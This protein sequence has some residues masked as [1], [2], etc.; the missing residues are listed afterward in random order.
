MMFLVSALSVVVVNFSHFI[1]TKSDKYHVILFPLWL[2]EIFL[3]CQL[4]ILGI[5][6]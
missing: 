5:V 4:F 3:S 1:A 6:F 2:D